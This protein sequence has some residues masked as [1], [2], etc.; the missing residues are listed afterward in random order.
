MLFLPLL[1]CTQEEPDG[2][3]KNNR[4]PLQVY[5]EIGNNYNTR[6]ARADSADL[7]SYIYFEP[8]DK[9]GFYAPANGGVSF[10][11]TP[12]TYGIVNGTGSFKQ[13]NGQSLDP[14]EISANQVYM[15]FP[16]SPDI[17]NNE[18]MTLRDY[19]VKFTDVPF[20][21]IDFLRTTTGLD[22]S[23]FEKG[24]MA[25]I[26]L[27][28]FSELV[29]M[30]G[31]GFETQQ[32]KTIVV[33]LKQGYTHIKI[34]VSTPWKIDYELV[35][36]GNLP[37]N[38]DSKLWYAWQG[39]NYGKS[40]QENGTVD[41]GSPAWYVILPNYPYPD[42]A[43]SSK[44][45]SVDYI[46]LIDN[47]GHTQTIKNLNLEN[48]NNDLKP[49]WRYPMRVVMK[50]LVPTVFPYTITEWTEQEDITNEITAGITNSNVSDWI[51]AYNEYIASGRNDESAL[52]AFGDKVINA[53]GSS[54]WRFYLKS[55]INLS[56]Y[57]T[58]TS[59]LSN[60]QD[61]LDGKVVNSSEPCTIS[62]L[63]RP[64]ADIISGN[65]VVQN[66]IFEK[67]QLESTANLGIV[68]NTINDGKVIN[69]NIIDGTVIS[70][71]SGTVGMICG[72]IS[73]GEISGCM[74]T[75]MVTGSESDSTSGYLVGKN[76]GANLTGNTS[77]VQFNKIGDD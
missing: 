30:R 71:E 21:C 43:N 35:D 2:K 65:G 61:V 34:I 60:L 45:T 32:D 41:E 46:Q 28:G 52:N 24:I 13:D 47:E 37:K 40:V 25:G 72:E 68:A 77:T 10:I 36:K 59:I 16:Y 17:S 26:F 76:T 73:G 42:G 74:A 29:I 27:H 7:W 22:K 33:A 50:D 69:C 11:N 4:I 54:Y 64:L 38:M 14:G 12:L 8:N 44:V 55:D 58:G 62:G 63:S 66:I 51:N 31:E 75:G 49:G 15:Y 19:N 39:D 57:N 23:K 9:L 6:A 1:S 5:A 18:G 70:S 56:N 53:D 20:C 48:D 3:Y 67:C